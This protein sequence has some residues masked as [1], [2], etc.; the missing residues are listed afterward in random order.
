MVKYASLLIDLM[1]RKATP[2]DEVHAV[3]SGYKYLF[4]GRGP[5][6]AKNN[7]LSNNK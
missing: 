5:L 3:T 6:T 7:N 2:E 1:V 4:S